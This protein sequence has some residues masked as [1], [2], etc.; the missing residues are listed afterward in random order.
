MLAA[1]AVR[2]RWVADPSVCRGQRWKWPRLAAVSLACTGTCSWCSGKVRVTVRGVADVPICAKLGA[3]S[4]P[5]QPVPVT[6]NRSARFRRWN[7]R[8][9]HLRVDA[10]CREISGSEES[11]PCCERENAGIRPQHA[12]CVFG[13]TSIAVAVMPSNPVSL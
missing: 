12:D 7:P 2:S 3:T 13:P 9:V 10:P 1:A 6:A 11:E 8:E 4:A 5:W